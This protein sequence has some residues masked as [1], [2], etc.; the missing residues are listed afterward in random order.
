MISEISLKNGGNELRV[1]KEANGARTYETDHGKDLL[2][3]L[4]T[5]LEARPFSQF[6]RGFVNEAQT[7]PGF[8]RNG[9]EAQVRTID[10]EV[11]NPV[12]GIGE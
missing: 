4:G 5:A 3:L 12:S 8:V 11:L 9:V 7:H 2:D 1:V 10:D 6:F